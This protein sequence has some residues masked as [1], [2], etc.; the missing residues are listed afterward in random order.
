MA[1]GGLTAG[2]AA[3]GAASIGGG[4]LGGLIDFP[5]Q[6]SFSVKQSRHQRKWAEYMSNTQ[7][8]RA[9]K[10]L[11]AA[12]LN[13]MLA[14]TQGGASYQGYDQAEAPRLT[15][16]IDVS[17]AVSSARGATMAKKELALMDAQIKKA[18]AEASSASS[19]SDYSRYRYNM[20]GALAEIAQ[21]Q[22]SADASS[23]SAQERMANKSVLDN[24]AKIRA[25][26]A[27]S[28]Q[29]LESMRGTGVGQAL[30]ILR[31]VLKTV[32]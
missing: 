27:A 23:A 28:A 1:A 9:V 31:E 8:Q 30:T 7:Y 6:K 19:M 13:P 24:E 2:Q 10:D 15:P 11:E 14:Y 18:E 25:A 20:H 16:E 26:D 12:G 29:T 3:M 17:K 21:M 22:G 5:I 32:R 4:I